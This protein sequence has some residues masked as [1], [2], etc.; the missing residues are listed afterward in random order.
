MITTFQP[1]NYAI[2]RKLIERNIAICTP[3]IDFFVPLISP[4]IATLFMRKNPF[5]TIF[6]SDALKNITRFTLPYHQ[7][8]TE[9]RGVLSKVY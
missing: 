5:D 8:L 3:L 6:A 2:M 4:I 1:P 7:R 9:S